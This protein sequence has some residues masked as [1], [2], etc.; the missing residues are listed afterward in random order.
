MYLAMASAY[1][2]I[3]L[4]LNSIWALLPLPIV[5]LIVDL[6]VICREERYLAAKFGD[7][8]RQYCSR[9]RRWF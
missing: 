8:Y 7:S 6:F 9:V 3:A 2:G 4:L 5:L 1:L